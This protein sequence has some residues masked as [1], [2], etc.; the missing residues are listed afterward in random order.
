MCLLS[1]SYDVNYRTFVI[2]REVLE[3]N[4]KLGV[5]TQKGEQRSRNKGRRLGL[6]GFIVKPPKNRRIVITE[7]VKCDQG[8]RMDSPVY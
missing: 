6:L 8:E 4:L 3:E 2:R 7:E 5:S 1:G